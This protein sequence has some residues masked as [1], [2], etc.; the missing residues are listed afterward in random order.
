MA[1]FI[2]RLPFQEVNKWMMDKKM[3]I[4]TRPENEQ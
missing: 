3:H 1:A 4:V 2:G